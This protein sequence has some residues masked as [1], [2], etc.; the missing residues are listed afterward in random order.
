MPCP[1]CQH[2]NRPQARFCEA[3]GTPITANP[4]GPPAPS[5][6]DVTS[7][8][9]ESL[10][11][12]TATGEILD[13]ISRSPTDLQPVFDAIA[14]RAVR[15]CDALFGSVYR[16]D[17]E[18]IHM[19]ADS[20]YPLEALEASRQLFPARAGRGLFTGRAILER[21]VVH[22]PDIERDP[23]YDPHP[24]IRAAGFRSVLSMPMLDDDAPIGAITVWRAGVG[25]FGD[26]QISLLR[27]FAAQAVIAIENVRLFTELQARNRELTESLEQQ[28]A[29]AEILRV[30]SSSPTDVQPVF[31]TIVESVVRLCDGIFTTVF[32]F[33]GELIHPVAYH[34]SI[35]P[36]GQDVHQ[37][38]YPRPPGQESVVARAILE[39]TV[40]HVSDVES[41]PDVP[42]ATRELAR[43]V[44]YQS[45]LAVR[46]SRPSRPSRS[47]TPGSS[48]RSPTRADSS[49]PRAA[50]SPSSSPTCPTSSELRCA[51]GPRSESIALLDAPVTDIPAPRSLPSSF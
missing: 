22:V 41:D 11:Q 2:E 26:K 44:G 31:D 18:L 32:R 4:S 42:A 1:R 3:C 46:P 37:R 25:P 23:E 34:R 47:R 39:R 48:E 8:L 35:G 16:F 20:N 21:A 45:V 14:E 36:E 38:R 33:D 6:A 10:E 7:A 9:T 43:T 29:T 5:Y 40:I 24:L 28:T 49:R 50:T 13:V 17:G 51:P 15:L 19:V 27:T 30:I 12:Q